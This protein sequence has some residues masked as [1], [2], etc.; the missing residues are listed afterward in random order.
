MV[1]LADRLRYRGPFLSA[2][3]R[4]RLG[5][6]A[7]RDGAL[8]LRWD[9]R[10]RRFADDRPLP[11][12]FAAARCA[13]SSTRSPGRSTSTTTR[14]ARRRSA[15]EVPHALGEALATDVPLRADAAVG[16]LS[17]A[18]LLR[19]VPRPAP[20]AMSRAAWPMTEDR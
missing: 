11:A 19:R 2:D 12:G 6:E 18:G 17:G 15:A 13:G 20:P 4:S 3:E 5:S 16:A 10:V 14:R 9:E 8:A 1:A 7:G